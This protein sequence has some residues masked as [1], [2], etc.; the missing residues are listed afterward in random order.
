MISENA[1]ALD[2]ACKMVKP[3]RILTIYLNG[4][5][6]IYSCNIMCIIFVLEVTVLRLDIPIVFITLT[7]I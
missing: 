3:N 4:F 1:E 5:K 7:V 6:I 2:F